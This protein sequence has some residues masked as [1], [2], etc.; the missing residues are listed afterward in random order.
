MNQQ[1]LAQSTNGYARGG[2]AGRGAFKGRT[3]IGIA[4]LD[5]A[6]QVRVA[7]ARCA[8]SRDLFT[9]PFGMVFVLDQN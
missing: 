4:V 1:A 2:F 6:G 9:L 3:Q 5:S 8:E 7:G